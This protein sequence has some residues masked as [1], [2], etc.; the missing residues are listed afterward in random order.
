MLHKDRSDNRHADGHTVVRTGGSTVAQKLTDGHFP[1]GEQVVNFVQLASG[2]A[3][4]PNVLQTVTS[5]LCS[6]VDGSLKQACA[7][8]DFD[9]NTIQVEVEGEENIPTG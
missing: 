1:V 3:V 7:N 9:L 5:M 2:E 8:G 6:L 4:Q